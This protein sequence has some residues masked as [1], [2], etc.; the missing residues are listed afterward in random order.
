MRIAGT[1][2][3]HQFD[4]EAKLSSSAPPKWG[5]SYGFLTRSVIIP[6]D[7][8]VSTTNSN[9]AATR[10]RASRGLA[11]FLRPEGVDSTVQLAFVKWGRRAVAGTAWM[12]TVIYSNWARTRAAAH[13][14]R[15]L[16]SERTD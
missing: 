11:R 14:A 8:D 5:W 13:V 6:D 4:V 16:T 7:K 15:V 10:F 2:A 1:T 3:G 12:E 9:A